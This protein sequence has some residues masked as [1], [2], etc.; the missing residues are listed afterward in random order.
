MRILVYGAG[1]SGTTALFTAIRQARPELETFFEPRSLARAAE[2]PGDLLVKAINMRR[3]GAE[4]SHA[5]SFDKRILLLR[6]PFDRLVSS[7]LYAPYAGRGFSDDR[8]AN[9]FFDRVAEKR[10]HPERVP[11]IELLD[12]LERHSDRHINAEGA[13]RTML[14]V[15]A[16]EPAFFPYK[17]E[18]FVAGRTAALADYLGFPIASEIRVDRHLERVHRRGEAGD[19]RN[20]LLASDV[21]AL[22]PGFGDYAAAFGYDLAFDPTHRPAIEAAHADA[23]VLR[24]VNRYRRQYRLPPFLPGSVRL[25]EEGALFDLA[26]RRFRYGDPAEGKALLRRAL[27]RNPML[28]AAR[29]QLLRHSRLGERLGGPAIEFARRMAGRPRR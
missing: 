19:W 26:V 8:R 17:Y 13:A 29:L 9:E 28:H 4:W 27:A 5:A 7:L 3:Y 1:R 20:W 23:F 6:H 14:A 15:A 16:G 24:N 11:F 22:A 25:G 18:D 2:T 12:L 10:R 21:A